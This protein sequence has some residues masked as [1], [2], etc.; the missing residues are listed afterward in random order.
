MGSGIRP[1]GVQ[2][3]ASVREGGEPFVELALLATQHGC[4]PVEAAPLGREFRGPAFDH[5]G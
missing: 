2:P 4:A 3:V 1:I 5:R